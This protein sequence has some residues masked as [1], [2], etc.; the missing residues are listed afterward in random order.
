MMQTL[1]DFVQEGK[2]KL[3][4]MAHLPEGSKVLVTLMPDEDESRFGLGVSEPTTERRSGQWRRQHLCPI[5]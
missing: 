5:T 2:I 1:W 3:L 4:E